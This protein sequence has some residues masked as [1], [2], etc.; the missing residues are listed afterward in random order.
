MTE[1]SAFAEFSICDNSESTSF[2]LSLINLS[3]T[4][5]N[6][7]QELDSCSDLFIYVFQSYKNEKTEIPSIQYQVILARK[8]MMERENGICVGNELPKSQ[9]AKKQTCSGND[10]IQQSG[11]H[12]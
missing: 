8:R 5:E 10:G 9:N 7:K 1:G 4:H 3:D 6:G 2:T 12:I 11:Y